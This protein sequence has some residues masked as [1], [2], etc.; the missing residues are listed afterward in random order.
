MQTDAYNHDPNSTHAVLLGRW[1]LL[2]VQMKD[3]WESI[4]HAKALESEPLDEIEEIEHQLDDEGGEN[5][6]GWENHLDGVEDDNENQ[7]KEDDDENVIR[8]QED[9]DDN[10]IRDQEDIL[11]D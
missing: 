4:V 7:E 11:M 3:L 6:L 5:N 9:D 10:V 1:E 8:D 2:I